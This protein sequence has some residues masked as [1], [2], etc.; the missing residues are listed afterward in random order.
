MYRR[1]LC[2]PLTAVLNDR[3]ARRSIC[4]CT[5]CR[6]SLS[7]STLCLPITRS[8]ARTHCGQSQRTSG[9]PR[10]QFRPWAT[11]LACPL[12]KAATMLERFG[13]QPSF[14]DCFVAYLAGHNRP[15]TKC[16]SQRALALEPDFTNEFARLTNDQVALQLLERTQRTPDV[17]RR[18]SGSY[19][20][21]ASLRL[22]MRGDS[23]AQ[24]DELAE[25]F[26]DLS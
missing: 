13:W 5:T 26:R 15:F 24:Q 16:C 19:S 9:P 18:C 21:C 3:V 23:S 1:T 22:A 10:P 14:A 8:F 4:S 17:S 7:T 20:T 12:R 11:A 2:G 25:R 6:G